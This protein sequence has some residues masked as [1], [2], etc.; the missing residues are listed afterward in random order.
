MDALP[1]SEKSI[2]GTPDSKPSSLLTIHEFP[3]ILKES[4]HNSER[5]SRSSSGLILRQSIK[6]L[7]HCPDVCFR[8][9]PL[10]K[11]DYMVL[12]YAKCQRERTHLIVAG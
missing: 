5:M 11:L 4:V 3:H 8:E 2:Q 6:P 9:K 1:S 10:Y 7:Q 12:S